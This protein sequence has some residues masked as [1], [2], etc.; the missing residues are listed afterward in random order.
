M[1][2][3]TL[4][5]EASFQASKPGTPLFSLLNLFYRGPQIFIYI[6]N[7]LRHTIILLTCG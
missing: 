7:L 1:Q 2:S 3:I 4:G 6:E 5:S